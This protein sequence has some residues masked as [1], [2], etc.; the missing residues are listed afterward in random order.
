MGKL[1][2]LDKETLVKKFLF[3]RFLIIIIELIIVLLFYFVFPN[4]IKLN[5]RNFDIYTAF[6][7]LAMAMVMVSGIVTLRTYMIWKNIMVSSKEIILCYTTYGNG[8]NVNVTDN[9]SVIH[10]ES[11]TKI[12]YSRGFIVIYGKISRGNSISNDTGFSHNYG[13]KY[14][15]RIEIPRIYKDEEELINIIKS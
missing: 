9:V 12:K 7:S 10:F 11:I 6:E 3:H 5:E 15:K 8:D 2:S 4:Y 1:F 13:K 14:E